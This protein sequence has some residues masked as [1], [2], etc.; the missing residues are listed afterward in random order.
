M[1]DTVRLTNLKFVLTT[2]GTID[3]TGTNDADSIEAATPTYFKPLVLGPI[4][5]PENRNRY[6]AG[7][8]TGDEQKTMMV[9][10]VECELPVSVEFRMTWNTGDKLPQEEAERILGLLQTGL[11]QDYTLGGNAYDFYETGNAIVLDLFSDK[12][13]VGVV[14]FIM[15]YRHGIGNPHA[16]V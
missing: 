1:V 5:D 16:V 6:A 7:I 14:H 11:Q 4:G 12:T 10:V 8:V 15:K 3:L 9:N 2:L 13:I